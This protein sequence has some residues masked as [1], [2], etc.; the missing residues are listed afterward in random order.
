MA[1]DVSKFLALTAL[2][3]TTGYACSSTDDDKAGDGATAGTA[4]VGKSG[5]AGAADG[6]GGGKSEAGGNG[7]AL[8]S[9]GGA[10]L[11]N[12]GA[13]PSNGGATLGGAGGQADGGE[14]LGMLSAG[15]AG[16][17]AAD[18]DPSLEDL[19]ADL[20]SVTCAASAEDFAP[21]DIVCEG[22]RERALPAVAIQVAACLKGLNAAG[23]CDADES[24][25]CFT[26]LVG[27]G[28]ENPDA[29]AA[30]TAIHGNCAA[31]SVA[32][33]V[34]VANLVGSDHYEAFTG[35]MDPAN[36]GWYEPDFTGTCS[37]RLDFCAGVRLPK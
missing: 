29:A 17:A 16:G 37:E 21:A 11:D 32:D 6:V 13:S 4:G 8:P 15:G 26:D 3:A 12:G 20:Y 1:F 34:K 31:V 35:C 33:C 9:N 28:C 27:Q 30:C 22:V 14:C 7:G 2:I 10:T 5:D 25:A 36:E 24:A 23:M 19:C 18:A